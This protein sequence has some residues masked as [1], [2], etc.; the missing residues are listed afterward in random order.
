LLLPTTEDPDNDPDTTDY[1][2]DSETFW[3]VRHYWETESNGYTKDVSYWKVWDKTG[4][5]YTFD[6]VAYYPDFTTCGMDMIRIWQWPLTSLENKFG[7]ELTY[8]YQIETKPTEG[9]CGY[10]NSTVI[11]VYPETITY[12]HSR[13]RIKFYLRTDR[14]DYVNQWKTWDSYRV[15][16]QQSLLDYI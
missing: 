6:H 3:R 8:S 1:H 9:S 10:R 13:Y 16:F 15:L 4:N 5:I 2:T 11:A 14:T 12:P 7:E